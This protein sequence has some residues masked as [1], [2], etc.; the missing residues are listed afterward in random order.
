MELLLGKILDVALLI[1]KL[2][3]QIKAFFDQK[4]G[5]VSYIIIDD[6]AKK[7]AIIDSVLNY[8]IFSATISTKSADQLIEFI[9]SQNLKLQWILETHIHAD[10]LTAAHYLREK[11]GGKIAIGD[12]IFKVLEYWVDAFNIKKEVPFDGS[13]FDYIFRDE[14]NFKIGNLSVKFIK[15]PGHTPACGSYLIGDAVFVGD[16]MFMPEAGTGRADFPGGSA[17]DSF[18]SIQKI[19]TLP[20]ETR[21]FTCH[22]Y[23]KNGQEAK[24]ESTVKKQKQ[25]NIF[26]KISDEGQYIKA[27]SDR[28]QKLPTP[29]LLLPSIQ[30]NIRC[31][32]L[33]NPEDNSICYLKIPLTIL[34]G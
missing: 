18:N 10:H 16:L 8:D 27:R 23:P 3:M 15:T 21:V 5:T 11:L 26:A 13:G 19:F 14:E 29:Q 20:D 32:K 17:K 7:C 30:I 22:N 25:Q 33:P 4:T 12:G 6:E 9:E 34:P 31:G 24:W 28:D 1:T 2:L